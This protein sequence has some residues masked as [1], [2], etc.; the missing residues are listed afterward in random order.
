MARPDDL[1]RIG[2]VEGLDGSLALELFDGLLDEDGVVRE[3]LGEAVVLLGVVA[4]PAVP[5]LERLDG[6]DVEQAL[7]ISAHSEIPSGPWIVAPTAAS[8][9]WMLG[10]AAMP[11]STWSA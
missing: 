1:V 4:L 10:P 11:P 3:E 9:D 7:D 5:G 6:L 8:M 2:R